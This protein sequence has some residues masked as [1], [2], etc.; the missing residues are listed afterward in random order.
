MTDWT[1]DDDI[2]EI[3]GIPSE[4]E[5]TT[6]KTLRAKIK[7]DAEAMKTLRQEVAAL[8]EGRKAEVVNAV[9]ASAGI[10]PKVGKFYTGE[11]NPT[12]VQA[13]VQENADVFG[14]T[15]QVPSNIEA[16]PTPLGGIPQVTQAELRQAALTPNEQVDYQR[17]LNAGVDGVP[18]S[19][20]NDIMGALTGAAT[21]EDFMAAMK[22]FQ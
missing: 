15:V 5:N 3:L 13:W 11:A 22:R 2:N 7:A 20:Y 17:M 6:V 9:L 10:N 16:T 19:N 1:N 18:P 12:A 14:G 4:G 21:Q 8:N